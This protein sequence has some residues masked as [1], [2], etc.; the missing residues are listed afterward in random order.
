MSKRPFF[1]LDSSVWQFPDY[2][3]A[4]TFVE[5]LVREGFLVR[6]L[7]VNAALQGQLNELSLRS[8][9]RRFVNSTGMT[10]HAVY[11]TER[12]HY[13]TILLKQGVSILGTVQAAGYADQPH[14]TRSLKQLIGQTPAQIIDKLNTEINAGLADPKLQA[15][16]AELG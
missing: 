2:E 14:L 10:H 5:R 8:I 3:N 1:Y 16:L 11:Q 6:E 12:A 7:V 4:D 15:R 9:Q 13:A